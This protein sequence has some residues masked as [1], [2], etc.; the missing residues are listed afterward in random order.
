[1]T[2]ADDR[3]FMTPFKYAPV[4]QTQNIANKRRII[5]VMQAMTNEPIDRL[6]EAARA[7]FAADI[8]LN[9]THPLNEMRG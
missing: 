8:A 6:D 3:R 9:V 7:G 4:E 2:A 1:M 5:E